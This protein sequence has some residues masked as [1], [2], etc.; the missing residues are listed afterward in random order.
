MYREITLLGLDIEQ[1][2]RR[3]RKASRRAQWGS[4][5]YRCRY[6]LCICRV[7]WRLSWAWASFRSHESVEDWIGRS[8]KVLGNLGNLTIRRQLLGCAQTRDARAAVQSSTKEGSLSWTEEG[9][10]KE[11]ASRGSS[12]RIRGLVE[13][14]KHS[15]PARCVRRCNAGS[16]R[17]GR[18]A[19]AQKSLDRSRVRVSY[20]HRVCATHC[21]ACRRRRRDRRKGTKLGASRRADE[22][23]CRGAHYSKPRSRTRGGGCPEFQG[24]GGLCLRDQRN[25]GDKSQK[26]DTANASD[27]E[28]SSF[29]SKNHEATQWNKQL[30]AARTRTPLL[31]SLFWLLPHPL[32]RRLSDVIFSA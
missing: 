2:A 6:Y 19:I 26:K 27:A 11:G 1:A 7:D 18:P 30:T 22:E 13:R 8:D 32:F 28:Q 21:F 12:G 3:P 10:R 29:E 4:Q 5:E 16:S 9:T 24:L 20:R 15:R 14:S 31:L 23:K 25:S 17:T